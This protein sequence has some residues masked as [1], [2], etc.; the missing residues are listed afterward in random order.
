MRLI[1]WIVVVSLGLALLRLAIVLGL[2]WFATS[3]IWALI[4]H[5]LNTI[6][7]VILFAAASI[8]R[9]HP[10]LGLCMFIAGVGLSRLDLPPCR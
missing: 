1:T 10:L 2:L 8:A 6:S 3:L 4:R 5:P 9:A 7:M